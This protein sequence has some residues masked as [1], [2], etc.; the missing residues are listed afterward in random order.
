[1]DVIEGIRYGT[2]GM[3]IGGIR[4]IVVQPHLGYGKRGKTWQASIFQKCMISPVIPPN[5]L[6][7]CSIELI[8]LRSS[9]PTPPK[10]KLARERK[11]AGIQVKPPRESK[12]KGRAE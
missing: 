3:R 8:D 6:L 7:I 1:M 9:A 10:L 2:E 4:H 5:A 12:R 11:A